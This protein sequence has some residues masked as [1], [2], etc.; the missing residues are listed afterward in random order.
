MHAA[1]AALT[2]F[3]LVALVLL[4]DSAREYVGAAVFGTAL[5]LLYG[6]SASYHLAPWSAGARRLM[7]RVDHSMIFVLIAGTYTPF[8]L[9]VLDVAWGIPMLSLVW[10]LA[11][12][13]VLLKVLRPD[14]PRWLGVSLYI[15]LGWV[16]A[17]AAAPLASSLPMMAIAL[18][19]AGGGLY[20]L[21]A[22]VYAFGRPNPA[23]SWFG[24][25]EIF[26]TFVVAGSAV[27]FA[28]ITYVLR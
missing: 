9:V 10:T 12:A 14:A 8:C 15:L 7:K 11:A 26:H 4:A 22:M 6:S 19:L 17:I 20:T 13:G 3:A 23:P 1:A 2:P 18:L 24:F 28:L 5:L 21:G 16:G 27:H 25:H